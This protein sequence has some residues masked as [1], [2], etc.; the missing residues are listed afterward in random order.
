MVPVSV[1]IIPGQESDSA[2]HDKQDDHEIDQ[3]VI[4]VGCQGGICSPDTKQID[5]GIA[6]CGYGVE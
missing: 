1:N 5:S 2:D 4:C 3:R 6:E